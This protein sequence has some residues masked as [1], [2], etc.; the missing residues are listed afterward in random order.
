MDRRRHASSI[1][2]L[3]AAALVLAVVMALL[4]H[5]PGIG[6]E[7]ND[8]A[9]H[10]LAFAVLSILAAAGWPEGSLLRIGERLSFVGALIEVFQSIP[11]LHRDCDVMDW[12]TDTLAI[13]VALG[14]VRLA[15]GRDRRLA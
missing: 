13:A 8:K 9:Q 5:P 3:F 12:I 7:V 10:S 14:I 1:R 11:A 6:V 4:P 15:R 2:L